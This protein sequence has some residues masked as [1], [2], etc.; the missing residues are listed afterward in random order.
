MAIRRFLLAA[1]LP[2]VCHGQAYD[3]YDYDYGDEGGGVSDFSRAQKY[4]GRLVGGF[5]SHHHQVCKKLTFH[6]LISSLKVH[7]VV[8]KTHH[9]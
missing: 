4:S 5:S 3:D 8:Q 6:N 9:K 7:F 2:L 1:F